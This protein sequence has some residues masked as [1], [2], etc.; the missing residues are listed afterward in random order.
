M[1]KI[2]FGQVGK[3]KTDK[4][5]AYQELHQN[6]WPE[7]LDMIKQCNLINYSIFSHGNIAFAY[8][9]YIGEDFHA[10][11]KKME[12]DKITQEWWKHTKPCFETY[13]MNETDAYYTDMKR[14]FYLE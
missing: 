1:R 5:D 9:E 10:D 14:I 12:A 8:F 4:I 13:A 3:L 7:V 2:I 6:P 11:M